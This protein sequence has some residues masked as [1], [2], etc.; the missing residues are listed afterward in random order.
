MRCLSP[1]RRLNCDPTM[2]MR[3]QTLDS[4]MAAVG[5]KAA[6]AGAQASVIEI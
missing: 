4:A 5:T 2:N 3:N 1:L 6:Y